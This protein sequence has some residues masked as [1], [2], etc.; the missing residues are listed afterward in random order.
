MVFEP[1]DWGEFLPPLGLK[2]HR[3][4]VTRSQRG[5]LYG[6]RLPTGAGAFGTGTWLPTASWKVGNWGDSPPDFFSLPHYDLLVPPMGQ[7]Q[8]KA[9]GSKI[10]L[11]WCIRSASGSTEQ[12]EKGRD[13]LKGKWM[14][15][16]KLIRTQIRARAL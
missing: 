1:N 10:L 11:T 12:G 7:R 13:C 2:G 9:R 15:A 8:L 4:E 3:E 6:R 16:R 5:E 14:I